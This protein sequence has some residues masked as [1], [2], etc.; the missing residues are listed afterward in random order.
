MRLALVV[1]L[2]AQ[3]LWHAV[4]PPP[5]PRREAM[6]PAPPDAVLR[7]AA[8]GEPSTLAASGLLWLQ[9]HDEQP[10]LD[11]SWR[12]LDYSTLRAWLE[13]WQA[14]VPNSDYP[15]M[16]AVRIYGQVADPARQRIMLDFV[17]ASFEQRPRERWRWL[18]EAA[19]TARHRLDD[20][21]LALE[22]ARLLT[23]R[24]RA[25]EIPHW[26][27]DLQIFI[28]EDMGELEAA[29]VLIGGLLASGEIDDSNEI[30]FLERKLTA[31]ERRQEEHSGK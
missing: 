20:L 16:L 6:P 7:L 28:L 19:I 15:Q 17:R 23:E 9:F 11:I 14:L 3:L 26:A 8:L 24:T 21:P 30:R 2:V 10:G 5:S 13:R 27:R 18:A 29:R 4:E 22:Y 12:D 1:A 31:L 25:G